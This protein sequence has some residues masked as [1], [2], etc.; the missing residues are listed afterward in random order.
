M[1]MPAISTGTVKPYAAVPATYGCAS[2]PA[3][4]PGELTGS[5]IPIEPSSDGPEFYLAAEILWPEIWPARSNHELWL[6]GPDGTRTPGK[7][8]PMVRSSEV[9]SSL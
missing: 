1:D 2:P 8:R 6:T 7:I 3:G 5:P 9:H 4:A